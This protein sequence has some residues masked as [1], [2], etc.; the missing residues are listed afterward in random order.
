M[1][2]FDRLC[3]LVLRVLGYRT[4]LYRVSYEART[5]FIYVMKKKVDHLCSLVV[6]IPGYRS[7]GEG[8]IPGGTRGSE[9]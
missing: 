6:R 4:E 3:G 9:K 5:E 2:I 7:R 1:F 8:S